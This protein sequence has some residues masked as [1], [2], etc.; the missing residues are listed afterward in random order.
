M[1]RIPRKK[2]NKMYTQFDPKIHVKTKGGHGFGMKKNIKITDIDNSG[3]HLASVFGW[4]VPEH[5]MHIKKA[6]DKRK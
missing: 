3:V 4:E 1:S 6:I 5:L 2:N